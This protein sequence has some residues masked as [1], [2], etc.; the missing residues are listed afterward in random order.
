MGN[1]RDP[2][3]QSNRGQEKDRSVSRALQKLC[4]VP[5]VLTHMEGDVIMFLPPV[6][7]PNDGGQWLL[8]ACVQSDSSFQLL[9]KGRA[10]R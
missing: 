4:D 1:G 3:T 8:H 9:G 7:P 10:D 2:K 5:G 6:A